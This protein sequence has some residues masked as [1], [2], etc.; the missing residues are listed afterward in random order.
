MCSSG[1]WY[2]I[3]PKMK[4]TKLSRCL[5]DW[6]VMTIAKLCYNALGD[7]TAVKISSVEIKFT[8]QVVDS[9]QVM[10]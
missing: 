7:G 8:E 1:H 4:L 3:L 10:Q 9:R 5:V 2:V 6:S